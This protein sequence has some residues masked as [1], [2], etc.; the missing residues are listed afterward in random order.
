[1]VFQLL[2]H[3][4]TSAH[5]ALMLPRF[6]RYVFIYILLSPNQFRGPKEGSR[7]SLHLPLHAH[8]IEHSA[9]TPE[10]LKKFTHLCDTNLSVYNMT[11]T[12]KGSG[13]SQVRR[14]FQLL[15]DDSFPRCSVYLKMKTMVNSV[16]PMIKMQVGNLFFGKNILSQKFASGLRANKATLKRMIFSSEKLLLISN[17]I[18]TQMSLSLTSL[19]EEKCF[20]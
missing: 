11:E 14:R 1:M 17:Y 2:K 16:E 20:W 5:L 9:F 19:E 4:V 6:V 3:I 13:D 15:I 18:W 12:L 10:M 8:D 7:T